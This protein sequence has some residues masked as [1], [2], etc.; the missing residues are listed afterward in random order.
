MPLALFRGA[1]PNN[2]SYPGRRGT[3]LRVPL[4][5][6]NIDEPRMSVWNRWS[7]PWQLAG[8]QFQSED[9]AVGGRKIDSGIDDQRSAFKEAARMASVK[10][11]CPRSSD[12]WAPHRSTASRWLR[13]LRRWPSARGYIN[14]RPACPAAVPVTLL[15]SSPAVPRPADNGQSSRRDSARRP[16]RRRHDF[17]R[18]CTSC[19]NVCAL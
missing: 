18:G 12:S 9:A 13:R 11:P 19:R 16:I 4:Q 1:T 6:V 7:A 5:S 8:C 3:P 10:C 14:C 15:C 2:L 17:A